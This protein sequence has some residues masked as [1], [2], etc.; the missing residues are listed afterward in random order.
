MLILK[1]RNIWCFQYKL[2]RFPYPYT[3]GISIFSKC[4]VYVVI[5]KIVWLWISISGITFVFEIWLK[6]L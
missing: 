6:S 5:H 2:V 3:K 1:R 4:A